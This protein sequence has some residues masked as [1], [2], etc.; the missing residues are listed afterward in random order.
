MT[1]NRKY[2]QAFVSKFGKHKIESIGKDLD[3]DKLHKVA[4]I[5][6][7]E[8]SVNSNNFAKIATVIGRGELLL[9]TLNTLHK[10][11]KIATSL[12]NNDGNTGILHT[13]ITSLPSVNVSS[14]SKL[15]K[16]DTMY[17]KTS[18][19]VGRKMSTRMKKLKNG[20]YTE[21]ITKD[22]V[23]SNNE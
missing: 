9:R 5:I 1:K 8:G 17:F 3:L 18:F 15:G 7:K 6:V 14:A 21:T 11:G 19:S 20:P 13:G 16:N 4:A 12:L 2:L 22:F 23:D 10:S